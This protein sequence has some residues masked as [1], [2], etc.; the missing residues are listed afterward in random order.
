MNEAY[1]CIIFVW[2]TFGAFVVRELLRD[3]YELD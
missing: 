3:E 1:W 2:V